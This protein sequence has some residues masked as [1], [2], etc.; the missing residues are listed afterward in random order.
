MNRSIF[1][2]LAAL[3]LGAGSLLARDVYEDSAFGSNPIQAPPTVPIRI[4][5]A[6]P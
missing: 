1:T 2:L 5:G 3:V 6:Q 4:E